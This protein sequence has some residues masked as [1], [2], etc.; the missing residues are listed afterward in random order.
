MVL[1]LW[2]SQPWS[3]VLTDQAR[4]ACWVQPCI[5]LAGALDA[6]GGLEGE[7]GAVWTSTVKEK[8]KLGVMALGYR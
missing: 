7:G 1:P 3:L 8:E 4:V 5:L 2:E 6:Q